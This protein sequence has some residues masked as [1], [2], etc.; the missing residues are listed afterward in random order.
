[1]AIRPL[2]NAR[3]SGLLLLRDACQSPKLG[4]R[5][6]ASAHGLGLFRRSK[7]LILLSFFLL[8]FGRKDFA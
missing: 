2:R 8:V 1:M 4:S 6:H 7:P 5:I 3:Q